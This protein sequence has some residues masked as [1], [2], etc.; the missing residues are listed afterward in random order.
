MTSK[1]QTQTIYFPK[2][3]LLMM[4]RIEDEAIRRRRSVSFVI[5]EKLEMV[6]GDA[7]EKVEP[8]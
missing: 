2:D 5:M 4:Q 8:E 6:Y 7:T 3:K 1:N